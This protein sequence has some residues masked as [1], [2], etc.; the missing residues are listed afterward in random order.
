M[1]FV[2]ARIVNLEDTA[3][4]FAYV[5]IAALLYSFIPLAVDYSGSVDYP[6]TVGAGFVVGTVL[7]GGLVRNMM[8]SETGLSYRDIYRRCRA[9]HVP[10]AS[11]LAMILLVAVSGMDFV[12]FTWSTAH[13]DTAVSA[14][15]FEIWPFAWVLWFAYTDRRLRGPHDRHITSRVTYLLMALAM[16]AVVLVILSSR[17]SG[18]V[19]LGGGL[20]VAGIVLALAAPVASSLGVFCFLFSDRVVFG[21]SPD[22]RWEP[23]SRPGGGPRFVALSVNLASFVLGRAATVPVVLGLS[24]RE[25]GFA[26]D[27]WPSLLGGVLAGLFLHAPAATIVRRAHTLTNRREIIALQY[28]SPILAIVWLAATAG[29]DVYRVDLLIVGTVSI[30][31][32]NMLINVAGRSGAT[33]EHSR[34]TSVEADSSA[35]VPTATPSGCSTSRDAVMSAA[36]N[37]ACPPVVRARRCDRTGAE[38]AISR[39][40]RRRLIRDTGPGEPPATLG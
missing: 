34:H 26:S 16:P 5:G 13:V 25:S 7:S 40:T 14:A 2:V 29:I 4:A 23:S 19:G 17:S 35:T 15:L 1:R 30:V 36:R 37:P 10:A 11:F 9:T 39:R 24:W 6:L 31:T 38:P 22:L 18:D 20:P 32:L 28:L 27:V 21:S 8:Y 3:R 12:L 33:R